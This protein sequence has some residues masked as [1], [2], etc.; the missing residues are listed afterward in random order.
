MPRLSNEISRQESQTSLSSISDASSDGIKLMDPRRG[1]YLA[2]VDRSY[3]ELVEAVDDMKKKT[4][5]SA[6]PFVDFRAP[7]A[8]LTLLQS[9]TQL[10]PVHTG[11]AAAAPLVVGETPEQR[12]EMEHFA[13]LTLLS[14]VFHTMIDNGAPRCDIRIYVTEAS[15][16]EQRWFSATCTRPS[17]LSQIKP[18]LHGEFKV[19]LETVRITPTHFY[20]KFQF[21]PTAKYWC[22]NCGCSLS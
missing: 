9:Y 16:P 20:H 22:R 12:A 17:F 6:L 13:V 8:L 4:M 18:Y 1:D 11:G 15:P 19:A 7:A 10:D 3:R 2:D 21:A 5:E 14:R